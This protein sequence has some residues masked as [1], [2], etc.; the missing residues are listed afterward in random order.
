MAG[1]LQKLRT[2]TELNFPTFLRS[3]FDTI[4]AAYVRRTQ[5]EYEVGILN[6]RLNQLGL[7]NYYAAEINSDGELVINAPIDYGNILEIDNEG[8]L[9][10]TDDGSEAAAAFKQM[11]FDIDENGYLVVTQVAP[12]SDEEEGE[13]TGED[14]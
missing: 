8:F 1:V 14:P 11:R 5:Y 6:E 13:Q 9:I 3:L 4:E 12:N 2:I 10:L 7:L